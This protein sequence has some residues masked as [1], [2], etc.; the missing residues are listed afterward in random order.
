[1]FGMTIL[2][3][4]TVFRFL[5]SSCG[6]KKKCLEKILLGLLSTLYNTPVPQQ[7]AN[8]KMFGLGLLSVIS[9]WTEVVRNVTSQC[10]FVSLSKVVTE[11]KCKKVIWCCVSAMR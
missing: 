8:I 5:V 7:D 2:L 9:E 6:F 11:V 1:M 4:S 10:S 3:D